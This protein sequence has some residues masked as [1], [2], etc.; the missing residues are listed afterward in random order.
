LVV[1][2]E[3]GIGST[4]LL[5]LRSAPDTATLSGPHTGTT[6]LVI[7]DVAGRDVGAAVLRRQPGPG[8][9]G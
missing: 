1:G 7:G 2:I 8:R 6:R 3:S 5:S 9:Y 4:S